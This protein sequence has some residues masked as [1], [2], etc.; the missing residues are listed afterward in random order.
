MQL[1]RGSATDTDKDLESGLS[2]AKLQHR[3]SSSARQRSGGGGGLAA[4]LNSLGDKFGEQV[5][6]RLTKMPQMQ[7]CSIKRGIM[8]VRVGPSLGCESPVSRL[9]QVV[10]RDKF[11]PARTQTFIHGGSSANENGLG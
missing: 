7:P 2:I 5:V 1:R 6:L 10:R 8:R 3:S 9:P 11:T 4:V